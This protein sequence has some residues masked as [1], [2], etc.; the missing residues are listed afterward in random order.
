MKISGPFT[1][2]DGFIIMSLRLVTLHEGEAMALS[3]SSTDLGALSEW[4]AAG[5]ANGFTAWLGGE[6][7]W[8]WLPW[9]R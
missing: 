8:K 5:T 1:R 6:P 2:N 3:Y 4:L 7:W 9:F